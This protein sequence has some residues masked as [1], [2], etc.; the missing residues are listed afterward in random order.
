MRMG[1]E[2]T[3]TVSVNQYGFS[4]STQTV[5]P[6]ARRLQSDE[7]VE[8]FFEVTAYK[9]IRLPVV[10][11]RDPNQVPLVP[12]SPP[13]NNGPNFAVDFLH[14][15]EV[16]QDPTQDSDMLQRNLAGMVK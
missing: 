12:D 16:Y 9:P 7:Q 1:A 10:L 8:A 5:I 6:D 11:H 2:P 15:A 3:I 4:W 14:A 13:P